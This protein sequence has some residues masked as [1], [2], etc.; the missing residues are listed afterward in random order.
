MGVGILVPVDP[1]AFLIVAFVV[2]VGGMCC[3]LLGGGDSDNSQT[4]NNSSSYQNRNY[5]RNRSY[6]QNNHPKMKTCP[7][8]HRSLSYTVT[9]CP[10]CGYRF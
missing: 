2:I 5:N 8:C 10:W 4:T 1:M 6:T 3:A 9:R 7:S